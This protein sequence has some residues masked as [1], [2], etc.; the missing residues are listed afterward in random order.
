MRF[1]LRPLTLG[2]TAVADG[3]DPGIGRETP[4]LWKLIVSLSIAVLALS[5]TF[6]AVIVLIVWLV[7]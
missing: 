6:A 5:L 2:N 4:T 3:F 7:G 1:P